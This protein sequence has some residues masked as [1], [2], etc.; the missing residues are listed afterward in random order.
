MN[1]LLFVVLNAYIVKCFEKLLNG[2][3]STKHTV[4]FFAS[5]HKYLDFG[6]RGFSP[7][8]LSDCLKPWKPLTE[9]PLAL[10]TLKKKPFGKH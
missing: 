9:E 3:D 7:I 1:Y 5:C 10:M 4:A 8:H 2:F 6:Y